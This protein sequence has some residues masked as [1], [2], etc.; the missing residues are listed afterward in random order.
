LKE[1][2]ALDEVPG[3]EQQDELPLDDNQGRV[4]AS[5]MPFEL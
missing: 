5:Q 4:A 1:V 3:H 2:Q